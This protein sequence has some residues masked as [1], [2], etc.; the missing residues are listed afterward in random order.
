MLSFFI[1]YHIDRAP[2]NNSKKIFARFVKITNSC[3]CFPPFDKYDLHG[4]SCQLTTLHQSEGIP[5][6]RIE[7]PVEAFF[8]QLFKVLGSLTWLCSYQLIESILDAQF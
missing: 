2:I 5:V 3:F 1:A 6:Q 8:K 4:I 7:I